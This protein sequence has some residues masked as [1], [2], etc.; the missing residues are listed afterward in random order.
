MRYR[1]LVLLALLVF[2][3]CPS[4]I[5]LR[6]CRTMCHSKKLAFVAWGTSVTS[7]NAMRWGD[8]GSLCLCTLPRRKK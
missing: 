8:K 2:A 3:G 4:A 1:R 7:A 6:Q 5:T